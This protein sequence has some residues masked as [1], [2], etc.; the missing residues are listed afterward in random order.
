MAPPIILDKYCDGVV[1]PVLFSAMVRFSLPS[2]EPLT[3]KL[4][5]PKIECPVWGAN[6]LPSFVS[7]KLFSSDF[8][9]VRLFAV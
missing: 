1:S 8:F 2:H 7:V 4:T 5:E 3:L 9:I 6:T